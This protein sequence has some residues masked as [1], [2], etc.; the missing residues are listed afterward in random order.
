[1]ATW[2]RR[3]L[4][5]LSKPTPEKTRRRRARLALEALEDRLA[6]ANLS[7]LAPVITEPIADGAV[8]NGSDVH[9]VIAP[10]Q[11]PDA[12]DVQSAA[13]W[14]IWTTGATAQVVWQDLG[15]T[16]SLRL[17][18][19]FYAYG[20]FL[21][22]L[23]GKQ[24]L[25]FDTNYQLKVRV[26]DSSGDAA[27]QWS[28]WSLRNFKTTPAL[29]PTPGVGTWAIDQPG[30]KVEQVAGGLQLAVD[31]AFVPN[32]GQLPSDPSFYVTELYGTIA[33]VERNGTVVN[34][35]TGL[36][37]FNPT[38]AFPGSGEQGLA[39][40]CVDP[41]SGDLFATVVYDSGG[42]HYPKVIRLHSNDG[43]HTAATVTTVLAMP[44]DP[45]GQSHQISNITIGPDGKL[46]VH[47][48]DSFI[49]GLGQNLT[50]FRG[51]VLRMNFDGTAASDNP[52]YDP[53][54]GITAKDY[55]F[56][57]GYRNP[58][59]GAWRTDDNSHFVVENGPNVDR[60]S[61]AV[62]GRNYLF[63]GSDASMR[64]FA[65]YNWG[66]PAHAPVNGAFIQT[67][68]FN[69]SRYPASKLD[70]L[71]VSESGP[72]FA[73]GPITNGKQISEFIID[74]NGNLVSGP[75]RLI[76]YNGTGNSTVVG[77]A[78]GPDGL[79]FTDLYAETGGPTQFAAHV[80]RVKYIGTAA[81]VA[82][83]TL[84]ATAVSG[85]RINLTW[86]DSSDNE[87]GFRIERSTDGVNYTE[88]GSAAANVTTFDVVSLQSNVTYYFRV[89]PFSND[90]GN[91]AYSPAASS[92]TLSSSSIPTAPSSL[93]AQATSNTQVTLA[94]QN[95]ASNEDGFY[96]ELSQNATTGF[97]RVGTAP[98]GTTTYD[99]NGLQFGATYYFRVQAFNSAGI[100]GNSNVANATT[101]ARLPGTPTGLTATASANQIGLSWQASTDAVS[102][103][104]YRGTSP[105]GESAAPL[106]T[107]VTA[108]FFA[109]T[110]VSAG[111]T[112]YYTIRAVNP[113]GVGDPSLEASAAIVQPSFVAHV[114]FQPAIAPVPAGYVVDSGAVY[115]A[116]GN[117]LT[118]GWNVDISGD[119]RDRN[120]P[121]S[122][123]QRYDTLVHVANTVFWEM[124]VPN[125]Q[126]TVH[127]VS[128]D[129][130]YL[131]SVHKV[132]VE[133]T[134]AI[135]FTPTAVNLWQEATVT[136]TVADGKLT[137]AP[138]TGAINDKVNF[139]DITSAAPAT[140]P[141]APS[142]LTATA[143]IG[144]VALAWSATTGATSYNVYRGTTANGESATPIATGLTSASY[145]D[146]GLTAGLTYYYKVSAVNSAGEGPLS[147]EASAI[148]T[149]PPPVP[150]APTGLTATPGTGQVALSWG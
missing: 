128:G 14:Q 107:G 75:T 17:T 83:A 140:P 50:S 29:Q 130:G 87:D 101:L 110:T 44:N 90:L 62:A 135:N 49:D 148:P 59:G 98:A 11:D 137:I 70:H 47:V 125:G 126:Y 91:G 45:V 56:S 95:N 105:G 66:P 72:T 119:T 129:P 139:I 85:S 113:V 78:A 132:N 15:V 149:V 122:P 79:Y 100:S 136:V 115:G 43:G 36:L 31:I 144:Q 38:G 69:G 114:N 146:G 150:L 24:E 26:A 18:R 48:G 123:D 143:G 33:M 4:S 2:L 73:A 37:N 102:Y 142:G 54:D 58:F 64:N 86:T 65:T 46:W 96:I 13:D 34:Y 61:K 109:D 41:V 104:V 9:M 106:A 116:R 12:G 20:Q 94:W 82:P 103:N 27:T 8:L 71:F 40:V 121:T 131:D 22:G 88:I 53:S 92:Q 52:F 134:L 138:A 5:Q 42:V 127:I 30:Y 120:D 63:D 112:Y 6:P 74:S 51:K 111:L 89:R 99:I 3:L 35:A 108:T 55:V 84:S 57:Y 141:P 133:G 80:F 93:T 68:D 10:F 97:V 67:S 81:P 32:P 124:A 60:L 118:Y 145:T 21:N 1:M 19:D 25:D 16:D 147:S 76:H 23:A 77:L 28:P 39:G 117:G 7:P